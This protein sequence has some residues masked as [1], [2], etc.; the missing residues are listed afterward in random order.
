M[1]LGLLRDVDSIKNYAWGAA[2]LCHLH[3]GLR[4]FQIGRLRGKSPT[5]MSF[6]TPFLTFFIYEHM[7]VIPHTIY[8]FDIYREDFEDRELIFTFPLMVGW[9]NS[10]ER[11]SKNVYAKKKKEEF[12]LLLTNDNIT[13]QP[14]ARLRDDFLPDYLAGQMDV[15]FSRTILICFEKLAHH[16][17]DLCPLKIN[18]QADLVPVE[19]SVTIV[20]KKR[21]AS[22]NFD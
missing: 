8:D 20:N 10:V 6:C 16:R 9:S 13:W 12:D 22:Q 15:A 19:P 1:F 21:T 3:N 11:K 5:I 18:L 4:D 14:Y 17:P 2:L 7:P